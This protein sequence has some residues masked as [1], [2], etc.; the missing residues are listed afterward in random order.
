MFNDDLW[1]F[2]ATNVTR[3]DCKKNGCGVFYGDKKITGK[4]RY[5]HQSMKQNEVPLMD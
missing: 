2:V 1:G 3:N 4:L 5:N